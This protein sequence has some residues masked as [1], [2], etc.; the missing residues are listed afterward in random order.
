MFKIKIADIVIQ[1]DNKYSFIEKQCREYMTECSGYDM[2]VCVSEE[3]IENERGENKAIGNG[4]FSNGYLESLCIYRSVCNRLPKYDAF[5][6][7]SSVIECDGQA[8]AFSA[9]S[10]TGKSTHTQLW[11]DTFGDRARIINGDKPI[12]RFVNER[13]YVYGTPWCGKEGYNVNARSPLKALCFLNRGE[14]N[15]IV[16]AD[17]KTAVTKLFN[18]VLLPKNGQDTFLLLGLLDRMMTEYPVYELYCNISKEAA[19]VAYEG[20]KG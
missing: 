10:G 9:P 18:Q 1:I 14:K 13:L 16:R 7:H 11:L 2:S 17:S 6:L 5:L 19:L 4:D 12:F 20:M 8:F 3:D 15:E